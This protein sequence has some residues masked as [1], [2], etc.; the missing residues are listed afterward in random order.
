MEKKICSKYENC[1]KV[2]VTNIIML[3]KQFPKPLVFER[4]VAFRGL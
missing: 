3:M 1:H 4:M 2:V